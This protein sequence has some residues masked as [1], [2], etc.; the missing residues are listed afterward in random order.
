MLGHACSKGPEEECAAIP[1]FTTWHVGPLSP[2]CP[3]PQTPQLEA[4]PRQRRSYALP[5]QRCSPHDPQHPQKAVRDT[6]PL[7][8]ASRLS[9]CVSQNI[10]QKREERHMAHTAQQHGEG[11]QRKYHLKAL[12]TQVATDHLTRVSS[13]VTHASQRARGCQ[14]DLYPPLCSPVVCHTHTHVVCDGRG[15]SDAPLAAF[16]R[17][18][19]GSPSA[20]VT[21]VGRDRL[22]LPTDRRDLC[23]VPWIV[24][25]LATNAAERQSRAPK[26]PAR[27]LCSVCAGWRPRSATRQMLVTGFGPLGGTGSCCSLAASSPAPPSRVCGLCH[28]GSSLAIAKGSWILTHSP[29]SPS[30]WTSWRRPATLPRLLW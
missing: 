14:D 4:A 1:H 22:T 24:R 18:G 21:R 10:Q 6:P 15:Y 29:R 28:N 25:S 13:T 16:D 11:L 7:V 23:R 17:V 27:M 3:A 19:V 2:P 5:L 12:M 9:A 20:W 8:F 30:C 26:H